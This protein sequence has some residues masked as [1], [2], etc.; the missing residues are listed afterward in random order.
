MM[1]KIPWMI[2]MIRGLSFSR[3]TQ[4]D[5]YIPMMVVMIK[6]RIAIFSRE[7]II[8]RSLFSGN[9]LNYHL[10]GNRLAYHFVGY[11]KKVGKYPYF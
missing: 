8:I 7:E 2:I 11:G 6:S 10:T 4:E 9:H 1:L 5:K 3:K